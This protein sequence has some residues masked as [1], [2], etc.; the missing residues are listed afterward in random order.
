MS[1][2]RVRWTCPHVS[3]GRVRRRD[4]GHRPRQRTYGRTDG[5][6]C[7]NGERD[8]LHAY[9]SPACAEPCGQLHPLHLQR[10]PVDTARRRAYHPRMTP[11]PLDPTPPETPDDT[12]DE[13]AEDEA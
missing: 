8:P 11:E 3:A 4:R 13:D 7:Y 1:A 9:L 6:A 10:S 5:H 12:P 2:G